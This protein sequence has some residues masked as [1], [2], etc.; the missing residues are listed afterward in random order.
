MNQKKLKYPVHLELLE[1][2]KTQ[3]I[4]TIIY[5]VIFFLRRFLTVVILMYMINYPFFQSTLLMIFSA[6]NLIYTA[7]TLPFISKITNRTEIFN[8]GTIYVNQHLFTLLL[9]SRIPYELRS[10]YAWAMIF[11]SLTNMVISILVLIL[12]YI[13][14]LA[15]V[16]SIC[17]MQCKVK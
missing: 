9:D 17:R 12:C 7:S 1:D 8:E 11:F 13:R 4:Q 3:K 16:I 5:N 6:L 10:K 2:L 14:Q 15:L